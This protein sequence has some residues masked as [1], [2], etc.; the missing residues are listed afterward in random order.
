MMSPRQISRNVV[1]A[2]GLIH[3]MT[4]HLVWPS[5]VYGKKG[6]FE[7]SSFNTSDP[8]K[9]DICK[10]CDENDVCKRRR[11]V[12]EKDVAGP[13]KKTPCGVVAVRNAQIA[14]CGRVVST[15][16]RFKKI[17][18]NIIVRL[19]TLGTV[20]TYDRSIG[21]TEADIKESLNKKW[22]NPCPK[23]TW[24]SY[25]RLSGNQY[26][27][28]LRQITKGSRVA[29]ALVREGE[30]KADLHWYL[31]E[32]VTGDGPTCKVKVQ[33]SRGIGYYSCAGFEEMADAVPSIFGYITNNE[34]VYFDPAPPPSSILS[35]NS[36]GGGFGG[37]PQKL[38]Y[39]TYYYLLHVLREWIDPSF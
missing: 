5:S 31:V 20:G 26:I 1:I 28:F 39:L 37:G 10:V 16:Y 35:G 32:S 25:N 19:L 2:T 13:A 36:R 14:M 33:D 21:M 12:R 17:P 18:W 22:S 9:N 4:G 30:K 34:V 11:A 7:S 6:T 15:D 23:G 3:I 38:T 24:K 29:L 27:R 8:C